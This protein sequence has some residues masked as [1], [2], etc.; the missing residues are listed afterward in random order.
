[1]AHLGLTGDFPM[2]NRADLMSLQTINAK[3]DGVATTT[4]KFSS[5]R[6]LSNNLATTDIQGKFD[7]TIV[8]NHSADKSITVARCCPQAPRLTVGQ[9]A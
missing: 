9:Q 3:K 2:P 1:M 8:S 5:M 6:N 7:Q 4:N